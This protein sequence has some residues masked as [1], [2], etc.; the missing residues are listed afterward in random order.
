MKKSALAVIGLFL[1]IYLLPLGFRPLIIPDETRYGEIPREMIATG[2]WVVPRLN[3]LRYFEKPVMGYWLNA[4]SITLFGENAFAVRFPSALAAGLSALMLYFLVRKY[5]PGQVWGLFTAAIFLTSLLVVALGAFSV[6]DGVLAMFLSGTVFFFFLGQMSEKPRSKNTLLALAGACA[7]LAFL[8]KGFLAFAVPVA[9]LLPWVVW[10][11]RLKDFLGRCWIPILA[12]ILVALPW[13]VMIHL[14]EPDFWNYF[15]WNEHVR[16]FMAD[17]AQHRE[18]FFFY[19]LLLP[20]MAMPWTFLWPAMGFGLKQLGLKTPLTRLALC[21]LLFPLLFFSVSSGKLPTYILPCLPPLTLLMALG[22]E[23]YL[24]ADRTRAFNR[25]AWA[26]AGLMVLAA[27]ALAALQVIGF[28]GFKP[29]SLTWKW[30]LAA[31]GLVSW[32]AVSLYSAQTSEPARKILLFALAPVIFLWIVNF[33]LPDSLVAA[34]APGA[35]L[36]GYADR[37][38]RDSILISDEEPLRA[39]CWYY[40]RH[41]VYLVGSPDELTYGLSYPE[42]KHRRLDP[43]RLGK[44]IAENQPR[45]PVTLVCGTRNYEKWKKNLPQPKMMDSNGEDA[46]VIAQY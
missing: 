18:S 37:I 3:G 42:A 22:L 9:A 39:V 26:L 29:Y 2:D 7:G 38:P 11:G 34:K 30:V 35:F 36:S 19:F 45:G 12:A 6:L 28:Q 16:R 43:D 32:A 20:A 8:T 10:E 5:G 1:I 17:N 15:F 14:R 31:A 40:K 33:T 13:A 44:M 46:F 23:R 4:L 24:A 27:L 41:D 25:G 21:W